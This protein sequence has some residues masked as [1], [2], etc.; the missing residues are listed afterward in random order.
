MYIFL[1]KYCHFWHKNY[2][3]WALAPVSTI[4]FVFL[5][6][7]NIV[8]YSLFL[9]TSPKCMVISVIQTYSREAIWDPREKILHVDINVTL[10]RW[11]MLGVTDKSAEEQV[12]CNSCEQ[13]RY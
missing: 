4:M 11:L 2:I 5:R 12:P 7:Y 1:L 13:D 9:N 8:K 6:G 10:T 3:T